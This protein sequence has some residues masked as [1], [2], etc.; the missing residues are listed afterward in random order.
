MSLRLYTLKEVAQRTGFGVNTL[1]RAIKQDYQQGERQLP[2]LAAKQ[3]QWRAHGPQ[4]M[5]P[6][7]ALADFINNL[8]DA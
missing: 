4:Y 3:G 7:D 6:E 8:P 1:K 5:I 2:R